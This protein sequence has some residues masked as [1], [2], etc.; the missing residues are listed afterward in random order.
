MQIITLL[1]DFG[2]Q[3][4]YAGVLHGVIHSI[5]PQA[6][7]VDLCHEV[8]PQDVPAGAYLLM[9]AYA[10]FPEGTIHV[11]IVDPG[12]GTE[13]K[14]VA[15]QAGSY[16]FV[17]PDN[18]VL[19]WVLERAG[20]LTSAVSVED[21]H[22]RLPQMSNTFHGRDIMA[23]AAAHLANGVPLAALGPPVGKLQGEPFPRPR[24]EGARLIG[25]VIYIDHF[26]NC[27][28]N[29]PLAPMAQANVEVR[30]R[31]LTLRRTY[32][33]GLPGEPMALVGSA[34]YLEIAVPGGSAAVALG[35]QAGMPVTLL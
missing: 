35:L 3:D 29:M 4:A 13:R 28:T 24:A 19:R 26:G 11:A 31:R 18:G 30:G 9:T 15:V 23:P 20:G 21:P 14:I 12:V 25:Q 8:P 16:T 34:G 6:T 2:L 17:G 7:V 33:E 1:T 22:Y 10:Y 32:G 5:A 27:V